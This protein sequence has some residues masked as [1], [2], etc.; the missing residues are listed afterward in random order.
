M[1]PPV[2]LAAPLPALASAA[3]GPSPP[4]PAAE[5]VNLREWTTDGGHPNP[6]GHDEL[7]KP[8]HPPVTRILQQ[9]G[10]ARLDVQVRVETVLKHDDGAELGSYNTQ[11]H[12]LSHGDGLF[13]MY[14]RR[15]AG[16]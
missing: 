4:V 12:W 11:Q 9:G 10:K 5:V 16:Q 13:L 15:G 3:A 7:A 1:K 2:L 14:T 6:R 8:R